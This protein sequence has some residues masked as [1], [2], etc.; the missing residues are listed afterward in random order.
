[1]IKSNQLN[2]IGDLYGISRRNGELD[3][4]Y[5]DRVVAAMQ[6]PSTSYKQMLEDLDR[7]FHTPSVS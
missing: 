4:A 5:K 1:M 2:I 6:P 3:N 7:F